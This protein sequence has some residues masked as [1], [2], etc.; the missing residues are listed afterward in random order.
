M[1]TKTKNKVVTICIAV[2]LA[3]IFLWCLCRPADAFSDSERRAL[4][5]FPEFSAETVLSGEFMTEFESYTLDQFPLRDKLRTLKAVCAFYLFGQ[6]DNHDIYLAQG[7]ASKLEYPM[8]EEAMERAAGRFAY[9]YDKYLKENDTKVYFSIIPD[10]NYFLA[11]A[12]GYP[13]LSY[14]TF[15]E[16]MKKDMSFAEY[17]DITGLLTLKDFYR[18]DTHWKQENLIP[19]AG[20]LGEAMGTPLSGEYRVE[21]LDHPFYGV[22]YG[23]SAL[24]LA[25]EEI[26]Y[27]TSK[28]LENCKVFDFQNNKETTV[29]DMEKAYGK[30]PYEMFLSGSLSLMTVENPN[31]TTEKELILFRDSF[32]SSIAPLFAEGY[33]KI[34]LV[35]I[36]YIHPDLLGRYIEFGGQDVLFLYSTLVLNNGE[37]MK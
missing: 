13:A 17:I 27:L 21:T 14:E 32:G 8:K 35:D 28:A 22:Y 4:A 1:T 25:A 34:T 33:R 36:R 37:T 3:G 26:R 5:Q 11:E 16:E 31:A 6:K 15:F 7:Y 23:Q 2:L 9:V 18:T 24:P 19:V 20:A 30:D 10:K 29:Y 12:N